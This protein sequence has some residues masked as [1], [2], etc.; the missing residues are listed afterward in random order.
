MIGDVHG[1]FHWYVNTAIKDCQ[2]SIQLGDFGVGFYSKYNQVKGLYSRYEPDLNSPK[3]YPP[4]FSMSHR[5][6]RGNHDDPTLCR[7]HPN[8]LGDYG[9]IK[10]SS[11][12][13]I[14]GGFSID[15]QNRTEG[16]DFWKDEELSYKELD[17]MMT[18]FKDSKPRIVVSHE[19]PSEAAIT[20]FPQCLK[21]FH[22]TRT[23]VAM[24]NCFEMHS[25][26]TWVF[27]H[28]HQTTWG[29]IRGTNFMCIGS[30]DFQDFPDIHW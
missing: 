27:G 7:K 17:E 21:K 19:A 4:D 16:I 13:Y 30:E 1:N 2:E 8:Y 24:Q 29:K 11:I 10:E 18:L 25:P 12:F 26:E 28:Y 5:W 22:N 15:Y 20:F 14:S 23:K 9:F 6:L 3:T